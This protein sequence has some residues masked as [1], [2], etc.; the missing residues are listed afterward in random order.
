MIPGEERK[1]DADTLV[2]GYGLVASTEL[3]RQAGCAIE[4]RPA[5][6]GWIVRHDAD[7]RTSVDD[8]YVAGEPAGVAGAGAVIGRGCIGSNSQIRVRR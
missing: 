5:E 2:I 3:A 8:I 7:M 4:W 1:V 6:G